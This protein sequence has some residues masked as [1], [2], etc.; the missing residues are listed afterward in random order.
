MDAQSR[1]AIQTLKDLI[2]RAIADVEKAEGGHIPWE[3]Q[4]VVRGY[5]AQA[6][7][8][9]RL[10]VRNPEA[11]RSRKPVVAIS[12]ATATK[13]DVDSAIDGEGPS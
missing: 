2:D 7:E 9:G 10:L 6:F 12:H 3:T 5:I 8:E 11:A 1:R 13:G 4:Q